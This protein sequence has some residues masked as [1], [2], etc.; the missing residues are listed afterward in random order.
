MKKI[1][2]IISLLCCSC[3][4][5]YF[6]YN[7]YNYFIEENLNNKL[8]NNLVDIA[9]TVIENDI[10][11]NYEEKAENIPIEVDFDILKQKNNDII[12]WIYSEN[13][14]INFPV[15]QS[16]DNEFYLR[17]LI[18]KTYNRAG[19][20]FMDYRNNKDL[21][22][23]NTIIYGHNMKNN[24]M[25][26]TL[27]NYKEQSYFDEHKT[28][29]YLTENEKYKVDLIAGYIEDANSKIY[30]FS[31]NNEKEQIIKKAKLQ[32]TFKSDVEIND[33]D[34]FVTLSTC[35]YEY[36]DARYVLMGKIIPLNINNR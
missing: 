8:N 31:I 36:E 29:Y 24:S 5:F 26:G 18:D 23:W 10:Q 19:T 13:T 32:S 28:M 17:R 35:S 2:K 6:A 14:P 15:V 9:V 3:F 4:I 16:D 11:K 33:D 20:I 7:I 25:F 27:L 1:I 30:N 21:G 12:G 22:D 34:R